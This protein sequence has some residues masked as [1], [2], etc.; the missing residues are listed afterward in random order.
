MFKIDKYQETQTGVEMDLKMMSFV[1]NDFVIDSRCFESTEQAQE[2]YYSSAGTYLIWL[3][4]EYI[5]HLESIND[6]YQVK[7][8]G[9]DAHILS[10][11]NSFKEI[12]DLPKIA[13]VDPM[14]SP[15]NIWHTAKVVNDRLGFIKNTIP[16]QLQNG[17]NKCLDMFCC[18]EN[19]SN[20]ILKYKKV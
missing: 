16:N 20:K 13:A 14:G 11:I 5:K 8:K 6:L 15:A 9:V 7:I 3:C 1:K 17:Y 4:E 18:M 2:F 12:K 19:L 10:W